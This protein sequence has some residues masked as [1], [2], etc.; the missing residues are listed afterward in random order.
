MFVYAFRESLPKYLVESINKK[1][2]SFFDNPEK[3]SM[4]DSGII[5]TAKKTLAGF[6][7]FETFKDSELYNGSEN[8]Y[9]GQKYI[10]WV[11]VMPKFRGQGLF[12]QMMLEAQAK[13]PLIVLHEDSSDEQ[14]LNAYKK[15]GFV[16]VP[17]YT[18]FVKQI[19]EDNSEG[20][21]K[22]FFMVWQKV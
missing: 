1:L 15:L 20:L 9:I 8:E 4:N 22:Q 2:S 12:K 17:K 14:L 16:V 7:I 5:V 11:F 3:V 19:Q 13:Y 18:R 10:A 21:L 6:L